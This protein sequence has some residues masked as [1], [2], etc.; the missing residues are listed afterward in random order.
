MFLRRAVV[1]LSL[2]GFGVSISCGGGS[3]S[4]R[5]VVGEPSCANDSDCSADTPKC[6]VLGDCI[7]S[8]ACGT[9]EDCDESTPFCHESFSACQPCRID[10]DCPTTTPTCAPNWEFS[11]VHCAQC[12]VGDSST[13]PAGT[14]CTSQPIAEVDGVA[15]TCEAPDCGNNPAGHACSSCRRENYTGCD[16]DG[17]CGGVL[18]ALRSCY[19]ATDPAWS[20]ASCPVLTVP[21]SSA[22]SPNA[23][24]DEA[25][26]VDE[27]L[28]L[29]EYVRTRC[30]T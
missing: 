30:E 3:S 29:C 10:S 18:A 13:C 2:L 27:C 5:D 4:D 14:W 20:E 24:A 11:S 16:G 21:S 22:C 6:S 25:A 12:R 17:E 8:W 1:G 28:V 19:V 26:S 15:G 23:C 7:Q 9:D